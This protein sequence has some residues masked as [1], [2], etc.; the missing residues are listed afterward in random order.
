M[1]NSFFDYIERLEIMGFFVAYPL[2]YLL[3]NSILAGSQNEKL[4]KI[5]LL[6]PYGYALVGILFL[7]FQLKKLYPDFSFEHIQSNT[8]LPYLK[9][10][11]LLSLLFWIPVLSKK[12]YLSLLHSFVFF[13][14]L[15][16]DLYLITFKTIDKTVVQN[17]MRVFTDSLLLNH[18]AF[19]IILFSY[20]VFNRIARR[21]SL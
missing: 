11:A 21:Q 16:K 14:F 5:P 19:F 20:L 15:L 4:K 17:D 6:L 13:F 3:V 12:T 10:W 8:G 2:V 1:D 9:I 18:G 7:G